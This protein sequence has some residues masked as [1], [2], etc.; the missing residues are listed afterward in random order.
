MHHQSVQVDRNLATVAD[1]RQCNL[2]ISDRLD[3]HT[4]PQQSAPRAIFV[5][6]A[7]ESD[8]LLAILAYFALGG[9]LRSC[10]HQKHSSIG[11]QV[12]PA[13]SP[14]R[15]SLD[16]IERRMG[17]PN[18]FEPAAPTRSTWRLSPTEQNCQLHHEITVFSSGDDRYSP[19]WK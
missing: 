6:K 15:T 17:A 16:A 1:D 4:D 5:F 3:P 11:V 10:T 7:P 2:K 13:D 14:V 19:Y 8:E 12:P 18:G 9:G